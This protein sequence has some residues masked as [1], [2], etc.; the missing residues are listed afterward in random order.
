MPAAGLVRLTVAD[1][2]YTHAREIIERWEA[3][4]ASPSD[5]PTPRTPSRVSVALGG[6]LIGILVTYFF[7]RAPIKARAPII[8]KTAFWTNAED[9]IEWPCAGI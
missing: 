6:L 1:D 2:D 8:M 3:S 7:M 5:S 4:E 9:L